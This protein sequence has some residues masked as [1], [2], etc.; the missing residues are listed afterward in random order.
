VLDRRF[1]GLARAGTDLA[2]ISTWN[3]RLSRRY[4]IL[5]PA[6]VQAYVVTV[7]GN[8][9][10]V[11]LTGDQRDPAPFAAGA[12]KPAGVHLHWAMPDALLR[13]RNMA[14][15][16]SLPPLPD[17]W[18]LVRAV[19]PVGQRHAALTGWVID[20]STGSLTDLASFAGTPGP[21][22]A[23]TQ[24]LDPLDGASGGS[25]HWTASYAASAGRF[26]FHDPLTDIAAAGELFG[27]QAVYSVAGWWSDLAGDPLGA[28]EGMPALD[29]RLA[30]LGWRVVHDGDDEAL[31]AE[32]PRLVRVR[33]AMG[34]EQP[35]ESAPVHITGADGRRV[36]SGVDAVRFD[37][38]SPVAAPQE[39]FVGP[40]LPRYATLVHGSVLGV[41]V[42]G[43]LPSADDRPD[44][45]A[46]GLA[47]GMDIDDV[48]AAFAAA[49]LQLDAG[50]RRSAET[51]VAAFT[52]G[53]LEQ[54]GQPDGLDDLAEHEHEDGFWPLAGADLPAA[55]P[56]RL[57]AE[58]SA[59]AGPLKL[60]RKGRAASPPAALATSLDWARSITVRDRAQAPGGA[61]TQS[62]PAGETVVAASGAEKAA[63]RE[64]VRPAPNRT[65]AITATASTTPRA[66]CCAAIRRSA[67]PVSMALSR[68]RTWCRRSAPAR[69]RTRR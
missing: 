53:L 61:D 65:T 1:A 14:G 30:E 28:A 26:T 35:S 42:A 7:D 52:G 34:L 62:R 23:G 31:S 37:L 39:V 63:S 32:D 12:V 8:E 68:G 9:E 56:D 64:V 10:T 33:S 67:C 45:A 17:L 48:A 22:P 43:A 4:R 18:V 66:C 19:L 5:V 57:R 59:A 20:A 60:G 50:Q 69:Y 36:A 47:L 51:L 2:T 40:A 58:D 6:D 41:P 21:A 24:V 46:V 13:G 16:L 55:K 27:N 49:A 15:A 29:Q 25:P 54:L 38:A 3:P 11:D 44:Q